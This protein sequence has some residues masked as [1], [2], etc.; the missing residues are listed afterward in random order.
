MPSAHPSDVVV[1]GAGVMGCAVAWRLRQRGL[2]VTVVERGIP[3][4]E[5]SSAAAGILAPQV[6][7]DGP[8]PFLGLALR[9]RALYPAW[10]QALQAT[11]GIDVGY[12]AEGTLALGPPPGAA[13]A[14]AELLALRQ[15]LSWQQAAGLRVSWLGPAEVA[16]IEPALRPCAGALHF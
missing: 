1:I 7:C 9:S 16:A 14:E 4:A 10:V 5:A 13:E 8:G 15:R 11:T 6:E 3:G 2:S 12:R